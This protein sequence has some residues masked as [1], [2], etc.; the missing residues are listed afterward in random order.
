MEQDEAEG[1]FVRLIRLLR[2]LM[3]RVDGQDMVEYALVLGFLAVTAGATL[4]SLNQDLE[5]IFRRASKL[6]FLAATDGGGGG[7]PTSTGR[8]Q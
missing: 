1:I 7:T 3:R 8:P 2:C 5:S 4:P 6:V